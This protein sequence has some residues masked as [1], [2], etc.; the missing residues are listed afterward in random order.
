MFPFDLPGPQFLGFY[1]LFVVAVIVGLYFARR[2]HESGPLPL[3]DLSDPL[4]FACLRGGPKEVVRVATLGL[5]DRGVLEDTSAGVR[6]ARTV[7][8]EFVRRR[9]E[10]EVLSYF[11]HPVAIDSILN[12]FAAERVAAEEYE[13][14]LRGFRLVPDNEMLKTRFSLLIIALVAL[15]GVGAI[16]LLVALAAG[17]SNVMFLIIMM[18]VAVILAI[19][20]R[21]PY[22]TAVG[23]SYLA[24]IRTMFNGLHERAASIKPGSGSRELLWLTALFGAATLPTSAFPF[25][26]Q[27]WPKPRQSSSSGCGSSCGRGGGSGCGGGG[28][29]CGGCGS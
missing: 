22:R 17:R 23:D 28:G 19:K 6:R 12:H 27:L 14:Q 5:I 16:K 15:L 26:P 10:K 9:V 1:A 3:A 4:L 13:T 24:S 29:G 11:E 20:A 18:V 21:G 7:K 8:P 25:V 2:H